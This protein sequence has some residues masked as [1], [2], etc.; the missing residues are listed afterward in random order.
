MYHQ[1]KHSEILRSAHTMYLHILYGS[2]NSDYFP[3]QHYFQTQ[4]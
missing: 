3:T 2:Q 4:H 1:I